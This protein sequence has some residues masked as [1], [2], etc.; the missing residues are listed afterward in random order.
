MIFALLFQ[1]IL[2]QAAGCPLKCLTFYLRTLLK[3][4]F[5]MVRISDWRRSALINR[6][7]KVIERD[8]WRRKVSFTTWFH[9]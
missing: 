3:I 5:T 2:H 1:T 9:S 6:V 4:I 8:Q 7:I